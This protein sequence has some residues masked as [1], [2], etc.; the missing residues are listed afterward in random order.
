MAI[1]P[2]LYYQDV[3]R[4][5]Q[6]L[7]KAF[8]FRKFGRALTGEDGRIQHAAMKSGEDVIMMG[9]PP[10]STFKNPK[11]LGQATQCLYINVENV[12][13]HFERAKKVAAKILEEPEDQ[14]YGHRRYGVEDPEGHQWYFAQEMR[15]SP[16]KK[17]GPQRK[18][19]AVNLKRPAKKTGRKK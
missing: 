18:K 4:A 15:S 5:L 8:A 9:S 1:I 13:K 11:R 19:S 6:F 10:G 16:A 3:G 17:R 12:D 2:Y 7:S 14:S